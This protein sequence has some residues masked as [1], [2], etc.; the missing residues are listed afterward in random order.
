M[1]IACGITYGFLITVEFAVEL[2]NGHATSRHLFEIAVP[3]AVCLMTVSGW[4]IVLLG[5]LDYGAGRM[6]DVLVSA[7]VDR[8]EVD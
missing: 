4:P 1:G 2:L 6:V 5:I 7:V 3:V 8:S